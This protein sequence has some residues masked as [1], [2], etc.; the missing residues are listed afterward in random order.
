MMIDIKQFSE[1]KKNSAKSFNEQKA[2]IKKV[3]SGRIIKCEQCGTPIK[4]VL[5]EDKGVTGLF[6][7]KGCTDIALDFEF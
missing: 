3:M 5:P 1:L 7:E 4:L 6:C 2:L